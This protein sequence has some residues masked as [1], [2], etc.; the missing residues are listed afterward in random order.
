VNSTS[1]KLVKVRG[2]MSK[3]LLALSTRADHMYRVG[4]LGFLEVLLDT[5]SF[6]DFDTTWSLLVDMSKNDAATVGELRAVRAEAQQ[7]YAA[8][9]SEQ[10]AA[11][12]QRTLMAA[13]KHEVVTQLATRKRTL[14]G[15]NA[16][17]RSAIAAQQAAESAAARNSFLASNDGAGHKWA[18]VGGDPP[19]HLSRGLKVVWWAKSRLGDSYVYGASGPHQF[20][21][22]GLTMWAYGKVGVGLSHRAADQIGEGSLVSR[23][24]LEPGDLVF[25]GSPIH[26]VGIY[27]GG[28]MYIHAPHTGDVV[29]ISSLDGRSDYAGACRP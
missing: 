16:D 19:S 21:C 14:A 12:K 6:D 22:S 2:R 10:D 7:T 11:A 20:D 28:G 8:L 5:R 13:R 17:I 15:I 18:D 4:P 26:H 3:L 1:A 9:K 23:A 29:K 24:N 25:F 27:V